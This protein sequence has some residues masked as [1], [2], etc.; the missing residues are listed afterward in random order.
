[1]S[2]VRLRY[3]VHVNP[4]SPMF[5]RLNGEAELTFLPMENVWPGDRLDL[6]WRRVKNSVATGYTRFQNGDVLVP[7]ITP[8]FEASRSIW[9][10]DGLINGVGAGTTELHVL[11]ARAEI[12]PRFLLYVTHSY[13]FLKL[14]EAEMYGVAGQKRVPDDFIRDF[15]IELPDLEEQRRI[16]SFLDVTLVR[17]N[18]MCDIRRRQL[19]LLK[20]RRRSLFAE[21]ISGR[22]LGKSMVVHSALG[23]LCFDWKCATLKRCI[24][25]IGVGVVVNPSA[26]FA[27]DGLPFI[28]GSN[29][30]D[31]WFSLDS[32]KYIS[33]ENSKR[34][35]RSE[36]RAGD[37]VVVRAGYPGRAAVVPSSLE[38]ANCASVLLI[39]KGERL[40]SEFMA[41][42]FNSPQGREQVASVQYGAA[43]EQINVGDVVDFVIPIPPRSEQ[44]H[45]VCW[46]EKELAQLDQLAVLQGKQISLLM[47]RRQA[48][49]T[50]AV[51]GRIDVT[52]ARGIVG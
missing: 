1:M 3:V 22:P 8:T 13:P 32:V 46:L 35:P 27:N 51:T 40:I 45:L 6:S 23:S 33:P 10:A 42:F 11:R 24:P 17:I 34:L 44:F 43:Q 21:C 29:V 16:A 25:D 2:Q 47:E 52:T 4:S 7:K 20:E 38:G 12:D 36:L 26:Y 9:I 31:G 48:L 28:H 15:S 14:G 30:R 39:R 50:A 19:F 37:V 18:D 49:I 41:A 5:D